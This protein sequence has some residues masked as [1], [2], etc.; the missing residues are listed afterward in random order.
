MHHKCFPSAYSHRSGLQAG[1]PRSSPS[2]DGGPPAAGH[3]P[4]SLR[5]LTF[6]QSK[7]QA[8]DVELRSCSLKDRRSFSFAGFLLD[9]MT[10]PPPAHNI[11]ILFVPLKQSQKNSRHFSFFPGS[12]FPLPEPQTWLWWPVFK[13]RW[14]HV[15]RRR[16]NR[17]FSSVLET[18]KRRNKVKRWSFFHTSHRMFEDVR[19]CVRVCDGHTQRRALQRCAAFM[20]CGK[21][22]SPLP[23]HRCMSADFTCLNVSAF[24]S[25]YWGNLAAPCRIL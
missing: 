25:C 7:S 8:L 18:T 13:L 5:S 19:R 3:R 2:A 4:A 20:S 21:Y 10:N 22:D 14:E 23:K 12:T 17:L 15:E 24:V 11:R 9:V 1:A 16:K 6:F